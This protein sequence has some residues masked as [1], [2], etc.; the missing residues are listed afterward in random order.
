MVRAFSKY[1][2]VFHSTFIKLSLTKVHKYTGF[3]VLVPIRSICLQRV[4][5]T[6]NDAH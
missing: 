5:V 3:R 2:A 1:H 6:G 4:I